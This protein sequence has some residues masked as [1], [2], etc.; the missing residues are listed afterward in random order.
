[1][2]IQVKMIHIKYFFGNVYM[3]AVLG[4]AATL[5]ILKDLQICFRGSP[6]VLIFLVVISFAAWHGGLKA[7]F[8]TTVLSVGASRLFFS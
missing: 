3:A 6:P 7:G 5:F 2:P 8:L 4:I 1:M